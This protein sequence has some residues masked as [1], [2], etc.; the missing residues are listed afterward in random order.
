MEGRMLAENLQLS[1]DWRG[2]STRPATI[3]PLPEELA[4]FHEFG[5]STIRMTTSIALADG[6]TAERASVRQ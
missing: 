1:L 2:P 5:K 3:V 6:K 4:G